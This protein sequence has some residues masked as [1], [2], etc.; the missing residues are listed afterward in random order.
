MSDIIR[1]GCALCRGAAPGYNQSLSHGSTYLVCERRSKKWL[2]SDL[3]MSSLVLLQTAK[4]EKGDK[5][6]LEL[7]FHII[8]TL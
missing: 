1:L 4:S 7:K 8:M 5:S 6:I 3:C 2:K